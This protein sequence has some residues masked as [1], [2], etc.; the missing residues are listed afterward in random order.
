MVMNLWEPLLTDVLE[1]GRRGYRE[2]DQEHVCLGIREWTKPIVILL[3]SC[4]EE[5]ER[6][7]LVADPKVERP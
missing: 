7:W 2:A 5:T 6:I 1:G 3:A 4:V